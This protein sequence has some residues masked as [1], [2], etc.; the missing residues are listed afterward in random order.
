MQRSRHQY[1]SKF[2]NLRSRVDQTMDNIHAAKS[3]AVYDYSKNTNSSP[4]RHSRS[5]PTR[6][7]QQPKTSFGAPGDSFRGGADHQMDQRSFHLHSSRKDLGRGASPLRS[8]INNNP[9]GYEPVGKPAGAAGGTT[10]G[11]GRS[12]S[13]HAGSHYVQELLS[14]VETLQRERDHYM[15]ECTH[16]KAKNQELE[17]EFVILRGLISEQSKPTGNHELLLIRSQYEQ[18]RS[19]RISSEADVGRLRQQL[20]DSLAGSHR[21]TLNL[22]KALSDM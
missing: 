6:D 15:K 13:N 8:S 11:A 12:S 3:A 20:A 16:E 22:K 14:Q 18:E 1:Q 9:G 5:P 17:K 21:D 2:E 10:G 4:L 7:V 19:L